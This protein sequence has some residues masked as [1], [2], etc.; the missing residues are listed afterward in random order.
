MSEHRVVRAEEDDRGEVESTIVAAFVTD[1]M[2]RWM[3][4]D[5][6]QF[7][8]Y[9]TEMLSLLGAKAFESGTAMRTEGYEAAALWLPPGVQPDS[10]AVFQLLEEAVDPSLLDEVLELYTE[11]ARQRPESEH[12]YLPTI[13][14]DPFYQGRGLGSALLRH[15]LDEIDR[16][17]QVTYLEST[18][19]KNLPL[20]ERVG[21]GVTAE[22]RTASSP[23]VWAMVRPPQSAID[24]GADA[25]SEAQLRLSRS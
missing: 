24:L 25:S 6:E 10:A 11:L 1:P 23:T 22:V 19:D 17:Q 16:A 15:Q 5:S 2:I 8:V 9:Y 21:F 13:G 12:W 20:Y 18:S 3:L 4:P 14:T 7:L